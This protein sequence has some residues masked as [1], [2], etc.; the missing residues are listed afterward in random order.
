RDARSWLGEEPR[1]TRRAN[2]GR[3][4]RGGTMTI[5]AF[6]NF[7]RA[8]RH[9][10]VMQLATFAVLVGSFAVLA[11]ALLVHQNFHRQLAQWGKSVK[12][13]VYLKEEPDLE[14]TRK[15]AR[16]LEDAELFA[17]VDYVS[18]DQ[19]FEKFRERMAQHIP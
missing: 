14:E 16:Y 10:T 1:Q 7:K 12:V 3:P 11:M 17:K 6:A 2:S 5:G 9:Q 18:K 19:A 13:N 4:H 8:W 15:V